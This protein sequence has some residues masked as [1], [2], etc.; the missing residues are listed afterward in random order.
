MKSSFAVAALGVAAILA[1]S[2]PLLAA[3]ELPAR[4]TASGV[5]RV[6]VTPNYPPLEFRDPATNE[7]TGFDVDLAQTLA[8]KLGV[9][10]EWQESAF[11]QMI[12]ALSTGRVDAIISGMTDL[13]SRQDASTFVDYLRSGPQFFVQA[14]RASEFKDMQALCGKSVGTS[15]RT[16]FPAGIAVWSEKHCGDNAIKVVG[17]EGSADARTQLKQGRVDAGVQGN[18]TLPYVISQEPNVYATVGAAFADQY[19]G[20]AL[21]KEDTGLQTA[22]ASALDALIADGSYKAL[23]DKWQLSSDAIEKA[24]INAGQ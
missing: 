8:R 17:T 6:A 7:L 5:L 22:I 11:A 13:K 24:T 1:W 10:L 2:D 12:P 14:S 21:A 3:A 9:K 23:L 16:A 4:I 18:E 19:T 20:I 15:R